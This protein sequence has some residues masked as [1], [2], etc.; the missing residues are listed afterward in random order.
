KDVNSK[1]WETYKEVSNAYDDDFLGRA[2]GDIGIILTFAGLLSAVVSTFIGGMQ[3]KS[4]NTTNELLLHLIQIT[5]AG[6]NTVYD[7][8]NLSSSMRPPPPAAWA[9]TPAYISLALSILAAF[10]AVVGKQ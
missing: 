10:G 3:P 4:G 8:S 9:Q 6:P 2:H 5:A 7:I 1:F